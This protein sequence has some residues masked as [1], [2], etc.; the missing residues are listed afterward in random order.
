[1]NSLSEKLKKA[2]LTG[3]ESKVYLELL[4]RGSI[5]ANELSK[6]LS[7]DRTLTYQILNNLVE[8]G[9]VNYIIKKNKKFFEANNPENLLNPVKEKEI[10][11]K[12]L[13]PELKNIEKLKEITQEINVYEGKEGLRTIF[14]LFKEHTQFCSFGA[15][16]NAYDALYES[17]AL[18]KDLIKKGVTAR[19]IMSTK[20]KKHPITKIKAIKIKYLNL[21]SEAT[22]TIFGEYVMVHIAKEKPLIILMKNKEIA[23][24]YQNHFEV[25]W[26]VGK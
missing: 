1:M 4:K 21:E 10:F 14:R 18:T 24:S 3:N 20:Y 15:T 2:G 12:D 22:T 16:G 25:L 17:K 6:K 7:F 11:I 8:K 13:I 19:V 5:S 23:D 26:K 9:L